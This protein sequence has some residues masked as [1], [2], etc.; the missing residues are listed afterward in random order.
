[1]SFL[2]NNRNEIAKTMAKKSF[3]KS[4]KLQQQKIYWPKAQNI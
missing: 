2:P 3:L 4:A 1:M